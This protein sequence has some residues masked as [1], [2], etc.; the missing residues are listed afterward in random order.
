MKQW[1]LLRSFHFSQTSQTLKTL[2]RLTREVEV[3][4]SA[5]GFVHILP[6]QLASG[7]GIPL[8]RPA[9]RFASPREAPAAN[10]PSTKWNIL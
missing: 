7:T 1:N 9:R 2:I 6:D 10:I 3:S 8:D 5:G 4:F